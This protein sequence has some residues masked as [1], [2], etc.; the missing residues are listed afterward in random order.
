MCPCIAMDLFLERNYFEHKLRNPTRYHL[1][2]PCFTTTPSIFHHCTTPDPLM[3]VGAARQSPCFCSRAPPSPFSKS[4]TCRPNRDPS[5]Y[6]HSALAWWHRRP[7][8]YVVLARYHGDIQP[9][10]PSSEPRWETPCVVLPQGTGR[11]PPARF[12]GGLHP[13]IA[14][15]SHSE[16]ASDRKSTRLNSSHPV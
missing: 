11:H 3:L 15:S 12:L 2:Y 5:A 16:A 14:G 9:A 4:P 1:I 7:S 6:I 10:P 8:V 13:H